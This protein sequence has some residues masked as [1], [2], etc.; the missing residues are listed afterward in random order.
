MHADRFW[1]LVTMTSLRRAG[2]VVVAGVV[3]AVVALL[4]HAPVLFPA[5]DF[6]SWDDLDTVAN[7]PSIGALG[8]PSTIEGLRTLWTEPRGHLYIPVTYTVWWLVGAVG[9][10]AT[11]FKWTSSLIHAACGCL[12]MV[13]LRAMTG[14]LL[15]AWVASLVFVV[16]PLTVE[17]VAWVSG[18][19]DLLAAGFG[20]LAVALLVRGRG[21]GWMSVVATGCFG[22]ALLSKP[23]AVAAVPVA[24]LALAC[25]RRRGEVV[26]SR[27]AVVLLTWAAMAAATAIVTR[28]LQPAHQAAP[29]T[30]R[31]LVASDALSWYVEKTLWPGASAGAGGPAVDHGRSPQFVAELGQAAWWRHLLAASV[32]IAL[33]L[34]LQHPATRPAAVGGM[35]AVFAV[36]PYLGLASFDFQTYST[37]SEHYAYG[38]LLGAAVA[39]GHGFA[40]VGSSAAVRGVLYGATLA[41]AALLAVNSHGRHAHWRDSQSL[42]EQTLRAN[43]RSVAALNNLA[44]LFL[45][46]HESASEAH[47]ATTDPAEAAA[48]LEAVAAWLERLE[49]QTPRLPAPL[50]SVV[51]LNRG[52]LA[53]ARGDWAE[54]ARQYALSSA[55]EPGFAEACLRLGKASWRLGDLA[56]AEAAYRNAL[57]RRH[58][59]A[60][61]NLAALLLATGRAQD[62]ETAARAELEINPTSVAARG[63]LA[64]ALLQLGRITEAVDAARPVADRSAAA[65]NVLGIV[66]ANN[67]QLREARAYFQTA[68]R[69]DPAQ[70]IYR[71]NLERLEAESP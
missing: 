29:A 67:G 4:T 49:S 42:F 40:A 51:L 39:L 16:H 68:V 35:G 25:G 22:A 45:D 13:M 1:G 52:R 60:G 57:E 12:L 17:A 18:L 7:N 50:R 24:A 28:Q 30:T 66:A 38:F 11:A 23:S 71:A 44:A 56:A 65:A 15:T 53:E 36:T 64:A 62:A 26:W 31:L 8:R 58:P 14:S 34:G 27:S 63:N 21:R 19:K 41:V 69:L 2:P 59:R 48:A 43:P 32:L 47:A 33:L 6:T 9:D 70:P 61:A 5:G 55:S 46:R 10:T 54:A 3:L 37:V 20:L